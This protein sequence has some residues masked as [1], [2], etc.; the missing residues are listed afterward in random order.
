[1]SQV[2]VQKSDSNVRS[3]LIDATGMY[4]RDLNALLRS[5]VAD[6]ITVLRLENVCG[7][8]YI[9]TDLPGDI[10][11][12]IH[13]TPGNDLSAFMDGPQVTVHGNVQ[14]AAGN[15]MNF[16]KI[17]VNGRAGD[18]LGMSMR[19][20]SIF[21]RDNVG[22]RCAI[23]MKQYAEIRP[24]LVIGGTAQD[25]FGEYMAGGVAILLGL[26]DVPHN[27]K[28][29][30]TGMH[31]GAI[32]IRGTVKPYQLGREVGILEMEPADTELVR[33]AVEEYV[34]HFG[35][36][37]EEILSA[38]FIKLSPVSSRPYGKMYAP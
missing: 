22:Y 12:E 24:T 5:L 9:A 28:F 26:G 37:A 19:G 3:A 35:G 33:Q 30:G 6:G 13:G 1:M 27:A 8:R 4:Y 36:S 18:V 20:G 16:G 21:V 15:T 34:S 17:I 29:I 14:D 7:Q 31:G 11:I 23:H 2:T 38:P 25:F 10:R 32:Y